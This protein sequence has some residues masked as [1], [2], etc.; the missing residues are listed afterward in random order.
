MGEA[1]A[2]SISIDLENVNTV[3]D[4]KEMLIG[5]KNES[6]EVKSTFGATSKEYA[7]FTAKAA[8]QTGEV[9]NKLAELLKN[10]IAA[11]KSTLELKDAFKQARDAAFAA[12]EGTAGFDRFTLIAGEAKDK[13]ADMNERIKALDPSGKAQ[14]FQAFG[15]TVVGG[16]QAGIGAMAVFTGDNQTLNNLLLKSMALVQGLQGI[17]AISDAKKQFGS[18]AAILGLKGQVVATTELT[19]AT[20]AQTG[21]TGLA[22]TATRI[23]NSVLNA[24]PIFIMVGVITAVVAALAIFNA[25]ADDGTAAL[26]KQYKAN[27]DLLQ[28]LRDEYDIRK[29]V[30]DVVIESARL[31][32]VSEDDIQAKINGNYEVNKKALE[33]Q[34]KQA[35]ANI[36]L[37]ETERIKAYAAARSDVIKAAEEKLRVAK[38]T[39]ASLQ[40]EID[41]AGNENLKTEKDGQ[42]RSEDILVDFL[43]RKKAL[44]EAQGK[45]A[46]QIQRQIIQ[47]EINAL[48]DPAEKEAR[49]NKLNELATLDIEHAKQV[50]ARRLEVLQNQDK[51]NL[52]NLQIGSKEYLEAEI[53]NIEKEKQARLKNKYLRPD[54]IAAINADA[55]TQSDTLHEQLIQLDIAH[56]QTENKLKLNATKE[57]TQERIS[58]EIAAIGAEQIEQLK[59]TKLSLDQKLALV[60]DN[61]AKIRD[62]QKQSRIMQLQ[63]EVNDSQEKYDKLSLLQ[64]TKE[65]KNQLQALDRLGTHKRELLNAE[66]R[67]EQNKY[68]LLIAQNIDSAAK[69]AQ[70]KEEHEKNNL[71]IKKKYGQEEINNEKKVSDTLISLANSA[72]NVFG[73]F[74]EARKNKEINAADAETK[75]RFAAFD[76]QANAKL[77][78]SNYDKK[79][80]EALNKDREKLSKDYEAKKKEI[81]KAAFDRDKKRQEAA[82]I[83]NGLSA[84][85]KIAAEVPFPASIAVGAAQAI[86]TAATLA[87]IRSTAYEGGSFSPPALASAGAAASVSPPNIGG[88]QR[89]TFDDAERRRASGGGQEPP[90]VKAWVSVNDID[91]GQAETFIAH[92][93]AK[94]RVR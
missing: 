50:A 19:G 60:S 83:I 8:K 90:V 10:N 81:E 6:E 47:A 4:L 32:G 53:T 51:A 58:A 64:E 85:I 41:K 55:K 78:A 12:G 79:V 72:V 63:D 18:I 16:M 66:L 74:A 73:E 37:A 28:S 56:V 82:T 13:L 23:W 29:Q 61:E 94:A 93:R 31:R 9:N 40:V 48:N 68:D 11:A 25:T 42:K 39:S 34:K 54:E 80:E 14:A 67:L 33:D 36:K 45:D 2:L 3:G 21:A 75:A 30:Q 92:Q 24:N 91:A 20:V 84:I 5:I 38:N 71:D 52:A 17:Q 77:K 26:Q 46:Y 7:D 86:M 27:E 76:A 57:G 44:L 89:T 35:D 15:Q 59:S 65:A 43:K 1:L 69:L 62:L 70:L 87:K 49:V 88:Q 22:A